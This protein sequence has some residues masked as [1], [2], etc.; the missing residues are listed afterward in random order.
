MATA[1][2]NLFYSDLAKLLSTIYPLWYGHT[3]EYN[4]SY[5]IWPHF[6]RM[7]HHRQKK[8]L[9]R[10]Q[11]W[12]FSAGLFFY[13]QLVVVKDCKTRTLMYSFCLHVWLLASMEHDKWYKTVWWVMW[14]MSSRMESHC[15]VWVAWVMLSWGDWF[16][17][18]KGLSERAKQVFTNLKWGMVR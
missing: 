9:A 15:V 7:N 3:F 14:A 17:I 2:Y 1:E 8:G 18:V 13:A 6:R 11:E 10:L 12:N 5:L 16:D 4:L